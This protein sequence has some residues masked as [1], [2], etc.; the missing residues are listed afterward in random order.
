MGMVFA[1][2]IVVGVI[3]ALALFVHALRSSPSERAHGWLVIVPL[4]IIAG[5]LLETLIMG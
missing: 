5:W 3:L 2:A 4:L 1:L